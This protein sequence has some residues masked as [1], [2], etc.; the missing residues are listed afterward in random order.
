VTA[1]DAGADS[2]MSQMVQRV[3]S[4]NHRYPNKYNDRGEKEAPQGIEH[5]PAGKWH[6][7]YST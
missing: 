1:D 6:P 5:P 2:R 7:T 4:R 3:A